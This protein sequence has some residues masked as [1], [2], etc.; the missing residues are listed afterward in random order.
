MTLSSIT[1]LVIGLSL[2]CQLAYMQEHIRKVPRR[3][4]LRAEA[5]S[6]L[7]LDSC[8]LP[9]QMVESISRSASVRSATSGT[10]GAVVLA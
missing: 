7:S 2:F 1:M 5:V 6:V 8:R 9:L 4:S 10:I 3:N